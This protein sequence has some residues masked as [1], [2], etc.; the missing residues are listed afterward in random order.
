MPPSVSPS[1]P[2]RSISS[3]IGCVL[4]RVERVDFAGVAQRPLLGQRAG[5]RLDLHAA[6][7]DDVAEGRDAELPQELLGQAAGGHADGR[8]AGAGPLQDAADRAEILDRA[9]QVA[10]PGP[11][12]DRRSSSR[13]SL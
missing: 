3:L 5:A 7:L 12:A 2:Q 11:R 10:V 1:L 4:G 6:Q 9:G 13:S 8:L